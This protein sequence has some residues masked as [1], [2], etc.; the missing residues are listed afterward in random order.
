MKADILT[1]PVSALE[2]LMTRVLEQSK[3]WLGFDRFMALAL[4]APNLGYYSARTQPIGLMA[5][6]GSDFVTAP[7]MSPFFS[8]A[9]A[10]SIEEALRVTDTQEVWEFGAGTAEMAFEILSTLGDKITRYVILE[11]SVH[12]K[13]LQAQ[14]LDAFKHKVVWLTELPERFEGVVVGNEVLDAMPVKLLQR[15]QGQ[16][17]EVGVSKAQPDLSSDPATDKVSLRQ[18]PLSMDVQCDLSKPW[19]W[20]WAWALQET[21][22][23]PP[24]EIEGTHDYLTEI[25]P[26]GEAFVK[27]LADRLQKGAVFL[28]DYGFPEREYYHEQRSSGTLMCHQGH[29]ADS[30]PLVSVGL[31]DITAHVN[32]TSVALS[33]QE[34]GLHVLGYTTQAHFL[35]NSGLLDLLETASTQERAMAQKLIT[36]HEMG[37]LFKVIALG[38]G[39]MWEPKGFRQG[40]RSHTL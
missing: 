3:G 9:L 27:T 19:A 2:K 17:F 12:L 37:E 6:S 21:D 13:D 16:W 28:I 25:H 20:E 14:K 30:N 10:S 7:Q 36:E 11:V 8:R 40:D 15:Q 22:L 1:E 18:T 38:V 33:A 34:A 23:K 32:F 26:Q 39:P 29:L 5:S 35:I 31:K 24:L 4:Y